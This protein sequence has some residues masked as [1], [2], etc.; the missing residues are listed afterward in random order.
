MPDAPSTPSPGSLAWKWTRWW[1]TAAKVAGPAGERMVP[2]DSYF[3]GPRQDILNESVLKPEELLVEVFIPAPAP[4][5][6]QAWTKLKNRQVYDFA[7]VSVAAAFTVQNDTWMDGRIVLGGVA[8]VPYRA[9]AIETQLKGK[10]IKSSIKQAAAMI[11]RAARPMSMNAY[12]VD[13]AQTMVERTILGA[14][15]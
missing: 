11:G 14:L 13:I 3:V 4:G 10:N 1:R 15:A 5:T 6:K 7:I 9:T 12:K 2:F 8:P